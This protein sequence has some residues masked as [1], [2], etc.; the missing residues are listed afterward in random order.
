MARFSLANGEGIPFGIF[1]LQRD[2]GYESAF[3]LQKMFVV[4]P[5]TAIRRGTT[6]CIL[7]ANDFIELRKLENLERLCT[8]AA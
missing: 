1:D 3:K 6:P 5:E 4:Y 2:L 7:V 8:V